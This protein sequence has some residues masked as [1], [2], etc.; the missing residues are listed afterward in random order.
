MTHAK[1]YVATLIVFLAIDA[2]WLGVIARDFYMA[3]VGDLL[4]EQPDMVAAGLFYLGYP[5]G[6]VYFAV[7]PAL[8]RGSWKPA[9]R[10]GAVLGL[11]AYGTYELS[12]RALLPGWPVAM[13]AFDLLWGGVLTAISALGGY[14]IT[15]RLSRA[16]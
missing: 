6:I 9:M 3:Q 4:R 7:A 5:A 15:R 2:L 13:T 12:N 11:V 14:A 1:A 10:N 16:G 8:E